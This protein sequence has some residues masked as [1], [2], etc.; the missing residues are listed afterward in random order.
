MSIYDYLDSGEENKRSVLYGVTP[1][2]V[3][4]IN[5]PDK[6]GRVKV[7]I[8]TLDIP[9]YETDFIRVMTP[10]S[11]SG[12][13][14]MFHPCVGDEVLVA[15]GGGDLSRPYVLGS[16]WNKNFKQPS[17]IKEENEIRMVKTKAGHQLIFDDKSD[18][19]SITLNTKKGLVIKLEDKKSLITISDKDGKNFIK[20]NA[21]NGNISA[22]CDKKIK[23]TAGDTEVIMD[24]SSGINMKTSGNVTIKGQKITLEADSA[25]ELKG[26]ASLNAS[27][28]GQAVLKGAIVKIN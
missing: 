1:A 24:S 17:E 13:G 4:N 6:L 3:T 22:E 7:K 20:I 2:V 15:Y 19:E 26:K 16:L 25:L 9:D 27:S 21:E 10:M 18:E 28:D 14:F 23:L 11:G 8:L 5:D 12:W